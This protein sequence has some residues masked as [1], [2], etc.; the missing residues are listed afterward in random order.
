MN[1]S[2]EWW[3]YVCD[4]VAQAREGLLGEGDVY[5]ALTWGIVELRS[6]NGREYTMRDLE[7]CEGIAK[8]VTRFC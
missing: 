8:A 5:L 4:I 3:Q 1:G 7:A 2:F 6:H